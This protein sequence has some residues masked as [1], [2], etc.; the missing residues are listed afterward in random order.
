[1]SKQEEAYNINDELIDQEVQAPV[2]SNKI[3]Y[4][5]AII[6]GVLITT[7]V[8]VILVGH[9]KFDWFKSE[10][11]KIEA[12]IQRS[13]FKANY[14]S[15]EKNMNIKVSFSNGQKVKKNFS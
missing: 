9:F 6:T 12:N 8:S 10:T 5:I 7:A 2:K 14:F 15:E 11:Y 1:M 13:N 4:A 3:K